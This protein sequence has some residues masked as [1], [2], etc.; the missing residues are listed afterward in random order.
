MK[1]SGASGAR[2]VSASTHSATL[3]GTAA[4]LSA[5]PQHA[6]RT[7]VATLMTTSRSVAYIALDIPEMANMAPPA[8]VDGCP[9]PAV[10]WAV[11]RNV[12]DIDDV[13]FSH[14][15]AGGHQA[16]VEID[17]SVS[18]EFVIVHIVAAVQMFSAYLAHVEEAGEFV[19]AILV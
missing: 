1:N 5:A 16:S 3:D 13:I 14:C 4:I 10:T 15:S 2:P 7:R 9:V 12:V 6:H 11:S 19:V 17:L 18:A 8:L